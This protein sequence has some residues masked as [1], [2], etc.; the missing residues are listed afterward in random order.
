MLEKQRMETWQK[1]TC[2]GGLEKEKKPRALRSRLQRNTCLETAA[3]GAIRRKN[4]N[5]AKR[6]LQKALHYQERKRLQGLL[7][8]VESKLSRDW[9]TIFECRKKAAGIWK[10]ESYHNYE[11][12]C[13][14]CGNQRAIIMNCPWNGTVCLEC[15]TDCE[16]EKGSC[17]YLD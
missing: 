7:A 10:E 14:V 6:L 1:S 11:I 12:P 15:C 13:T 9:A 16:N 4:F 5:E 17:D 8:F 3:V 2:S